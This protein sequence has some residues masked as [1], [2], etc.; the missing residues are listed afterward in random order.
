MRRALRP[1]LRSVAA[2]LFGLAGLGLAGC[3]GTQTRGQSAEEVE[4][5][6]DLDVLTIGDVSEVGS[7]MPVQVS[8]VG[9]VTGLEG[10]GGSPPGSYRVM[11]EQQLRKQKVENTK[12]ILDS[13]DNALV[14]VTAWIPAGARKGDLLDIEVTLPQGS[15]ASSLRGG[16]LQMCSLRPYETSKNINPEYEGGNKLLPGHVLGHAKGPLL[17]AL[18]SSDDPDELRKARIWAGGVCHTERPFSFIL[19]KDAKFAKVA[20]VVA[21]RINLMFQDDYKKQMEVLRNK[22]LLVLDEVTAQL[23]SKFEPGMMRTTAKAVDKNVVFVHVPYS[24]RF[25]PERYLLVSR[26]IPLQE[27]QEQRGKYRQRLHK[28]LNEPTET[29]RA[30]L[31]LEALGKESVPALKDALQSPHPLVRFC[32]AESLAYLGTTSGSEELALLAEQHPDLQLGCLR[33]L[34][35][36]E[37]AVNRN[38][39]AELLASPNPPLRCGAFMALR[40]LNDHDPRL[41]GKLLNQSF[42]LHR[43]APGSAPLVN[44]TLSKRAE[45]VLFGEDVALLTP[46]KVRAGANFTITAEPR[47]DRC[48]VSRFLVQEDRVLRKQCAP[49]VGDVLTTLAELGGQYADAIDFLRKAEDQGCLTCPVR[50]DALPDEISV[51]M[52]EQFSRD[53]NYLVGGGRPAISMR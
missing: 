45:I 51:E 5:E 52:L 30:T 26:L 14:L 46:V 25:N 42:W 33:A 1:W 3:V 36:A 38:R 43:V 22:H 28:M 19:K 16:Y 11:L 21:D 29:V 49:R 37:D 47:D 23:N 31:R 24:Y 32:A 48:T 2:G 6:K 53:P 10:T 20:S 50:V 34:A 8:G 7:A 15:R 41:G 18:G 40:L 13:P 17:V 12:Q 39:L 4:R 27:T 44:F 9:L 35:C